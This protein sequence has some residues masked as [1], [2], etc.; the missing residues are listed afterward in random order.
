MKLNLWNR[1]F[2]RHA[3]LSLPTPSKSTRFQ[4]QLTILEDR[5]VPATMSLVGGS[6][7]YTGTN[8]VNTL[9][10]ALNSPNYVF[11][12]LLDPFTGAAPAG[13]TYSDVDMDGSFE[14]A[15]VANA[16]VNQITINLGNAANT[17]NLGGFDAAIDPLTV[18]G[19][20]NAA[21]SLTV[22]AAGAGITT[23]GNVSITGFNSID[24]L[25]QITAANVVMQADQMNINQLVDAGAGEITLSTL[26]LNRLIQLGAASSATQLGFTQAQLNNLSA[27]LLTIDNASTGGDIQ[28]AADMPFNNAKIPSLTLNTAGDLFG[29]GI[30]GVDNLAFAASGDVNLTGTWNKVAG[31]SL[32]NV[33]LTDTQSL[34]IDTVDGIAMLFANGNLSITVQ[35]AD[36]LLTVNNPVTSNTGNITFT[37][38][39]QAINNT[40]TATNHRVTLQPFTAG[41][42]VNVGTNDTGTALGLVTTEINNVTAA[43]LQIGGT[44]AGNVTVTADVTPTNVTAL[45]LASGGNISSGAFTV[46]I[47]N[48]AFAASGDVTLT[49]LWNN[50]A[51]TSLGNVNLTNNQD[52][53]VN[54]VDGIN[55]ISATGSVNVTVSTANG[56][57][58][59]A[60]PVSSASNAITL[61]SDR[62]AI[63]NTVTATGNRVIL[64][65]FTAARLIDVGGNDTP[66]T[67]GFLT[68]EL[69][70]VSAGVLQLGRANAGNI[71]VSAD[72]AAGSVNALALV[73]GGSATGAGVITTNAL[74]VAATA[75][76]V[77]LNTSINTPAGTT[78]GAFTLSNNKTL[79]IATVDGVDGVTAGGAINISAQG[80]LNVARNVASTGAAAVTLTTIDAAGAG[81][82]ILVNSGVVVSSAGGNVNLFAGD[83]LTVVGGATVQTT[84]AGQILF[85]VDVNSADP[86]GGVLQA[87][88]ATISAP[89]GG[90]TY[91][92]DNQDDQFFV[93][94][95]ANT[96]IDIDG[97]AGLNSLQFDGSG[98][99]VTI[100]NNNSLTAGNNKPVT[101]NASINVDPIK[102]VNAVSVSMIGSNLTMFGT[103]TG[104]EVQLPGGHR[105]AIGNTKFIFT[106]Q[107]APTMV[108]F[109]YSSGFSAVPTGGTMFSGVSS[110]KVIGSNNNDTVVLTADAGG[111]GFTFNGVPTFPQL[112]YLSGITKFTFNGG[113]GD[114]LLKVVDSGFDPVPAL[115][116]DY[117]GDDGADKLFV[118]GTG[119]TGSY[120][121]AAATPGDGVVKFEGKSINF[122]SLA[123]V[124]ITGFTSFTATFP[125]AINNI[126]LQDDFAY[127]L[128]PVPALRMTGTTGGVPFEA[129]AVWDV[130][131]FTIDTGL[132]AGV[133]TINIL[134]V[135]IADNVTNLSILTGSGD[136]TITVIGATSLPG[137]LLFDLGDN[138]DMV[139]VAA[140]V[141]TGVDF[142]INAGDGDDITNVNANVKVGRDFTL[143]AGN[144][145]NTTTFAANTLTDVTRNMDWL[146]G[147]GND[148]FTSNADSTIDGN[149]II[150]PGSGTNFVTLAAGTT[151]T[152]KQNVLITGG[153]NVDTINS[154]GT[155]T[156]TGNLTANLGAGND[157]LNLFTTT[158]AGLI[159]IDGEGNTDIVSIKG[160]TIGSSVTI[161]AET[162]NINAN[163]TSKVGTVR[164]L[165]V[166]HLNVASVTVT[167]ETGISQTGNLVLPPDDVVVLNGNASFISPHGPIRFEDNINGT[168]DGQ[169]QLTVTA[170]NDI[171]LQNIGNTVR[172]GALNVNS[173]AG[174][175]RLQG[176]I[177]NAGPQTYTT[178]LNNATIV[179][180]DPV[181]FDG[182]GSDVTFNSA[183]NGAVAGFSGVTVNTTGITSFNR[184]VGAIPLKSLTTNVGGTTL[185]NGGSV[186]TTGNQNYGDDVTVNSAVTLFKTS[187]GSITFN[188][189]L[190]VAVDGQDIT[191]DSGTGAILFKGD[192]GTSGG[193]IRDVRILSAGDVT[194]GAGNANLFN[195]AGLKQVSGTGVTTF[196][197][198]TNINNLVASTFTP[199]IA[200]ITNNSIVLNNNFTSAQNTRFNPNA[201][202]VTQSNGV[203]STGSLIFA[204]TGSFTMNNINNVVSKFFEASVNGTILLA[205][206]KLEINP[207]KLDAV[208]TSNDNVTFRTGS[209]FTSGTSHLRLFN[210][211]T[212]NLQ[213][214]PGQTGNSV[215]T[216]FSEVIAAT[217]NLGTDLD[218]PDINGINVNNV[219]QDTFKVAPSNNV[220]I[221]VWGN[222]PKDNFNPKLNDLL[223]PNFSFLNPGVTVTLDNHE[224]GPGSFDGTYTFS[225]STKTLKFNSIEGFGNLQ[226]NASIFQTTTG[227]FQVI[228]TA[229]AA[230]LGAGQLELSL[231]RITIPRNT[232]VVNPKFV[233]PNAPYGAPRITM[234]DINGDGT[235][236]L[237]IAA[238]SNESP[239]VFVLNGVKLLSTT[240]GKETIA[241]PERPLPRE[242]YLAQFLAFEL[243]Y[244]GGL[245]VAVGP[246]SSGDPKSVIF[247]AP[248]GKRQPGEIQGEVRV[249]RYAPD[250]TSTIKWI[251]SP[252]DGYAPFTPYGSSFIGGVRLAVRR[253]AN[254]NSQLITATGNG[255][256]VGSSSVIKIFDAK[257]VVDSKNPPDQPLSSFNPYIDL[258]TKTTYPLYKGSLYIATGIYSNTDGTDDLVVGPGA[259]MPSRVR[260]YSGDLLT[261]AGQKPIEDFVAFGADRSTGLVASSTVNNTGVNG[262]AFSLDSKTGNRTIVVGSGAGQLSQLRQ[263]QKIDS[264]TIIITATLPIVSGTWNLI[265][266]GM[267]KPELTGLQFNISNAELLAKL[268]AAGF[269]ALAVQGGFSTSL[270]ISFDTVHQAVVTSTFTGFNSVKPTLLINASVNNTAANPNVYTVFPTVFPDG[271]AVSGKWDITINGVKLAGLDLTIS[272]SELLVLLRKKFGDANIMNVDKTNGSNG[273]VFA[274]T[275]ATAYVNKYVPNIVVTSAVDYKLTPS[276]PNATSTWNLKIGNK[277]LT[278]LARNITA[279]ALAIKIKALI[280]AANVV[281]V[282]RDVAKGVTVITLSS[283]YVAANNPTISATG[284]MVGTV[285]SQ[286]MLGGA[287]SSSDTLLKDYTG[288][289]FRYDALLISEL[290]V[291]RYR[292]GAA[293]VSSRISSSL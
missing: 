171:L 34:T 131:N 58:T 218:T 71:A 163:L 221:N 93:S 210:L 134:S 1:L 19:G 63:N 203:F 189:T 290:A 127:T 59:I 31:T 133:D 80:A 26:S 73:T 27:G 243:S 168:M 22:V 285:K 24:V 212:G 137:S 51:G 247:I 278:N 151:T 69:G 209:D 226:L 195:V 271:K 231:P 135:A 68:T 249:F 232:F 251:N 164:L 149:F 121:P 142:T 260:V 107:P 109:D 136:D 43:T 29:A 184:V 234:G 254:G 244:S 14:T 119:R 25:N 238:G 15:T 2:S 35:G 97:G 10:V 275:F 78:N 283:A 162:I 282:T 261:T 64:Q 198:V 113:F 95:S 216:F 39:R 217:V 206:D 223:S 100:N 248:D 167:G 153:A 237:V 11:Q 287:F 268:Q 190:N 166:S 157:I 255:Q 5:V 277:I 219:H 233:N 242:F 281:G 49:G 46:T 172:L 32:G 70:Q 161:T 130:T 213:V 128:P 4:P 160:A 45:R 77:N 269:D 30:L 274:I 57:L 98:L 3:H 48:L 180:A 114:D 92:G 199:A 76:P 188:R 132:P 192:V 256:P 191:L 94:S 245:N 103:A 197:A 42:Q 106:G 224:V 175:I 91:Q 44:T 16:A 87:I 289:L 85:R 185:V 230:D 279:A 122:V 65:P 262:V 111:I 272:A 187:G 102:L 83:N 176:G 196:N 177:Y 148:T 118:Q 201:A 79:T 60:Q 140:T 270:I 66:T 159:A 288:K 90:A 74:R 222:I 23:A 236:D 194:V 37:S 104:V 20:G 117:N 28:I 9:N 110:Y 211:G 170:Q 246:A 86:E 220:I 141:T 186:T 276:N 143:D 36:N 235:E 155:L 124:D 21:S 257:V 144:G 108:T 156:V 291:N 129:L 41:R 202:G 253:V 264:K 112:T 273:P 265:I 152:V 72:V 40:V 61:S 55:G 84:G 139:N 258:S 105:F 54:T 239:L 116:V 182:S 99:A 286:V 200:D 7:T 56:L 193:K 33:S 250:E 208:T 101:F 214:Y 115:G 82:N 52:L 50:V 96:S 267:V 53:T 62:Q 38:D 292:D 252:A 123:P 138:V 18:T 81:Q 126:T 17:V 13:V 263:F 280:G 67:L 207:G 8:V 158:V 12:N 181:V 240:L 75:G 88:G 215:V 259:G 179:S 205:A 173:S 174:N 204:G 228:L 47:G 6:L 125:S 146:S 89:V 169:Q 145:N 293:S 165:S 229:S 227:D 241:N 183:L 266:D 154:D 147:T 284:S 225:D 120:T 178:S 150:I